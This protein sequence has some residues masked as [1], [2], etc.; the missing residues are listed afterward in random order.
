MST[1]IL[2]SSESTLTNP[3]YGPASVNR[4]I[5]NA[6]S[7]RFDYAGLSP[8][9]ATGLKDDYPV[10]NYEQRP[11][12]HGNGDFGWFPGYSLFFRNEGP[13]SVFDSTVRFPRLTNVLPNPFR[14]T[15]GVEYT[16][17]QT[18][19]VTIRVYDVRGRLIKTL[20]NKSVVGGTHFT[21]W[22]AQDDRGTTV[23]SGIYFIRMISL[24]QVAVRKA[25]VIR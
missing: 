17:P 4:T 10:G 6:D 22:N 15:T 20:V 7:T 8:D 2:Q 19:H 5:L 3:G 13:G 14:Y 18:G 16:M 11:G 21:F 1:D 24:G 25:L 23:T 12:S 9:V